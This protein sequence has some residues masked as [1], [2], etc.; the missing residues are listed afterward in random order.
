MKIS[1]KETSSAERK[2]LETTREILGKQSWGKL[3]D[4]TIQGSK[5]GKKLNDIL[6]R[7]SVTE[8]GSFIKLSF[9]ILSL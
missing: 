3:G 7:L 4:N 8:F 5:S 9:W 2:L 6:R 1:D